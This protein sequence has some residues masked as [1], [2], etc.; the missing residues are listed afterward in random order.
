MRFSAYSFLGL[1]LLFLS[2]CSLVKFNP[3]FGA[4]SLAKKDLNARMAVRSYYK[5]FSGIVEQTADSIIA[6]SPDK[7]IQRQAIQWKIGATSACAYTAFQSDAEIALVDTWLLARQMDAYLQGAGANDFGEHTALAQKQASELHQ[8]IKA[9][10]RKVNTKEHFL[11]LS[12]F[13]DAQPL[14]D[15]IH[16]WHFTRTD[17]RPLLIEHLEIP[18]SLY[19]NT[20]GTGAE[21][22]NDFTDRISVYNDQLKS[23]LKWE[24]DLIVMAFNEDSLAKP[25]LARIDSLSL[26]LNRLVIVAQESP[27]MLGVIAV[28]MREEL[29]PVML[30]FNKGMAANIAELAKER[31]HLQ[32][33]L[34]EQRVLLKK[35][36][37]DSGKTLIQET[38]DSLA[39]LIKSISWVI[40]IMV[41]VLA[42]VLFGI[43]FTAGY[44]L[45]KSRYKKKEDR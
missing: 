20:I 3:Q 2:S 43:P 42:L 17:K 5:N 21:V 41:I 13:I 34:D 26:M 36:I 39:D 16:D 23:Q 22:M 19:T 44:F 10:A 1:I 25:Y 40:I 8:Q 12:S 24:K 7:D 11:K 33:Y 4:E 27:E 14:S 35:D 31:E 45:A 18:D 28:K 9:I 32:L 15:N 37:E 6:M 30:D 38:A 29:S